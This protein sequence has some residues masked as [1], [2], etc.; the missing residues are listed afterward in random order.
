M[1]EEMFLLKHLYTV[2]MMSK[3]NYLNHIVQ[4]FMVVHSG[5]I[6]GNGLIPNLMLLINKYLELFIIV[7]E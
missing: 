1:P 2:L 7:R 6:I 4:V 3:L 5:Q